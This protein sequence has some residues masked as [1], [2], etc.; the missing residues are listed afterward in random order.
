MRMEGYVRYEGRLGRTG[1]VGRKRV[2]RVVSRCIQV[3]SLRRAWAGANV[4]WIRRA[5]EGRPRCKVEKNG[6]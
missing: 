3:W 6:A 2:A 4:R 1:V 5:H